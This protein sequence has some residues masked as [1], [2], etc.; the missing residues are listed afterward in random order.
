M[1]DPL[2]LIG[3]SG[4]GGVRGV[5]P[6]SPMRPASKPTDAS[7]PSF[8][9]VLM[10]NVNEANKLQQDATSAIEDLATG[11]RTDVE[12]VLLATAKADTAFRLL[13]SVRNKVMQAYEEVKQMRV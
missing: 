9:D 8:K 10:S 11:K 13:Q 4:A 1:A 5:G 3:A 12:G 6:I 7:Q 2:G